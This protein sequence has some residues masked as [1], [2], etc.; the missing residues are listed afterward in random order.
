[1]IDAVQRALALDAKR[2]AAKKE[3]DSIAARL[4]M[5]TA[6]ER[7]VVDLVISGMTN[8]EIA[9][10]LGVSSQAIDG[11]RTKAMTKMGTDSVPELVK[12]M[13]K[14]GAA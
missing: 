4:A 1:L 11:R 12:L 9:A 13:V 14:V 3:H 2:R 7:E 5:L 6:R 8:K 10:R